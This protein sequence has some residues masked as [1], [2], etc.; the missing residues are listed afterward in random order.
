MFSSVTETPSFMAYGS[1]QKYIKKFSREDTELE[2]Y[3]THHLQQNVNTAATLCCLPVQCNFVC[4]CLF[5]MR[6][7]TH[8]QGTSASHCEDTVAV[9]SMT[10]LY[11]MAVINMARKH[12]P[13]MKYSRKRIDSKT[14]YNMM[15]KSARSHAALGNTSRKTS[16]HENCYCASRTATCVSLIWEYRCCWMY[17]HRTTNSVSLPRNKKYCYASRTMTCLPTSELQMLV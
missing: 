12:H 16:L 11:V 9:T 17:S 10:Q 1:I 3:I 8:R 6:S 2:T 14:F 7:A 13:A 5:D 4:V 15:G